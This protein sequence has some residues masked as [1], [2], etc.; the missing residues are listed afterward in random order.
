MRSKVADHLRMRALINSI[1]DQPGLHRLLTIK[2]LR[3]LIPLSTRQI[4]R[5]IRQ[6]L[7]PAPIFISPNRRAW[8]ETRIRQ[9]L[10]ERELIGQSNRTYRTRSGARP[11][12]PVNP[13]EAELPSPRLHARSGNGFAT[14][15]FTDD[16]I[17]C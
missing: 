4:D 16:E 9:Y 17:P 2:E 15:V 8:P 12:E 3:D 5:L 6:G 1:A 14:P 10:K 7:F 13:D 11:Q